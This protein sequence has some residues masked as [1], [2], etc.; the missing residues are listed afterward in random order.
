M[1]NPGRKPWRAVCVASKT[2]SLA[3]VCIH[4]RGRLLA[5]C[6]AGRRDEQDAY[7]D[8]SSSYR[9]LDFGLLALKH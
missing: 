7:K 4:P 9:P 5:T 2:W 8:Q 3:I 1:V 6:V